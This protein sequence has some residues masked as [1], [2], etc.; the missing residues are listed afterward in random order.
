M[1]ICLGELGITSYD[2]LYKM[3]MAEFNI[4]LFAFKR[5]SRDKEMLFRE[6]GYSAMV[7]SHLDPKKMPK[8]KQK[9]WS[10]GV[11]NRID[12]K[13]LEQNKATM[14]EAYK[15]YNNGRN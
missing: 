13:Q 11:D 5:M 6:V 2:Y 10:I 3:T 7:G 8:T 4:R 15:Q 1:S 12:E 14:L 9:Y